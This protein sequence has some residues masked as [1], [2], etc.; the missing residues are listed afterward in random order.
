MADGVPITPGSGAVVA[1]DDAGAAGQVQII[2]LAVSA[3]GSATLI[4]ADSNGLDV[5]V[6]R[7]PG[8]VADGGSLPAVVHIVG[9]YDGSN[10][11]VLA[12]DNSGVLQ[13][14]VLDD[15]SKAVLEA[16]KAL[17]EGTGKVKVA[18]IEGEPKVKV[19]V[20]EGEPKVKL[21]EMAALIAGSAKIGDVG[22]STRTSGGCSM[23]K[24]LDVDESEDPVKESV[25]QLYGF[26]FDNNASAKR[27]LKYYNATPANVTVGTTEPALTFPLPKE[28]AGTIQLPCPAAF[29]TAITI[30]ATTG[31]PDND[32]GAPGT[33]EIVVDTFY[34]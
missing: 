25:G 5:D 18:T 19:S 34:S 3:D 20:L 13:V 10:A 11:Q 6:T 29:S 2:K 28:T 17:L 33:G 14:D 12:T 16:V 9:G 26:Y 15:P 30:A 7:A 8:T 31:R 32:T 27:Y 4:G 23:N 1:S 24:N 21:A 22:I